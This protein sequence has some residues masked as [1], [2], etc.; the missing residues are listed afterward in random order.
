MP[1]YDYKCKNCQWELEAIQ[2]ISDEPLVHCPACNQL[3][4]KRVI[5]TPAF[6]LKGTGWE[7]DGY[8]NKLR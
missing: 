1:T 5:G 3:E 2:R 6:I 4:L 8:A 7:R